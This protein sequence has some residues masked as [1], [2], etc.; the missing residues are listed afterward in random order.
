M[1]YPERASFTAT[2]YGRDETNDLALL[3]TEMNNNSAA[4]FRIRFRLGERVAAYGFPYAGLLSSSGNFTLGNVTSES[5]M[6]DDT[7]FFKYLLRFNPA[8]VGDHCSIWLEAL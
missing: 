4:S 5:G 6:N 8:I 1:R 3:H 2:L 7:V